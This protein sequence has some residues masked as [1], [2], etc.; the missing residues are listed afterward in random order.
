MFIVRHSMTIHAPIQ[1]C[2]AL[3]CSVELVQR[4]LHM[5]PVEGR[6][7]GLVRAGDTIRWEGLQL[8][9]PNYHVSEILNFEP[10][11]FFT[12][13]MIA[14]RFRSFEHDHR[15]SETAGGTLL[16]DEV[17]FTMPFGPAGWVVGKMVLCPHVTKLLHRRFRLLKRLAESD[18]WKE[19]VT[20]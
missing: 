10:P 1:R 14:G 13:R 8:G 7:S 5:T 11:H 20:P 18:E 19:Y 17:R 6:T 3:S 16:Q 15:L 12:D 2:F 4:E 9:F